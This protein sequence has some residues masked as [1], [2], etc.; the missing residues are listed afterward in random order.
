MKKLI[1]LALA[2]CMA[3]L[4]VSAMA[5]TDITGT[6]YIRTMVQNGQELDLATLGMTATMTFN[7]DGTVTA[8][9]AGEQASG[10][11]TREGDSIT[12][13]TNDTPATGVIQDGM[14]ILNEAGGEM[15]LTREAGET[16]WDL[17]P[18]GPRPPGT[19]PYRGRAVPTAS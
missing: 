16:A 4:L 5:E 10:T 9:L 6:W 1:S 2:L 17:P 15:T 12:A 19:E 8:D 3:C 14:I 18:V 13:T 11:W 7:A